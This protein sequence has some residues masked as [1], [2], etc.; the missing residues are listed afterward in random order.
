MDKENQSK[1]Y[2]ALFHLLGYGDDNAEYIFMGI[3]EKE[4]GNDECM[5]KDI[6]IKNF[7]N[8]KPFTLHNIDFK[9]F[10]KIDREALKKTKIYDFYEKFMIGRNGREMPRYNMADNG[11]RILCGNLY[12]F[13]RQNTNKNL[14]NDKNKYLSEHFEDRKKMFID[15]FKRRVE[16]GKLKYILC[17][18]IKEEYKKIFK[19]ILKDDRNQ[20][21]EHEFHAGSAK[22]RKYYMSNS[23]K[24]PR[25]Y[26]FNH[27][28]YGWL[29][30]EQFEE[31]FPIKNQNV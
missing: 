5:R 27:P 31:I 18:G 1:Y 28:S 21:V 4:T 14:E 10:E 24:F 6:Y 23:E 13:A 20:I 12:P 17:F 11:N 15:Y 9:V 19:E 22:R 25:I 26:L 29:T 16:D 2:G 7:K 3:E 8:Q 30:M